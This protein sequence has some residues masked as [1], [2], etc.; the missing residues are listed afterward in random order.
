MLRKFFE[1]WV[2]GAGF[3]IAFLA[4][5]FIGLSAVFSLG[6]LQKGPVMGSVREEATPWHGPA[7]LTIHSGVMKGATSHPA[8]ELPFYELPLEEKIARSSVI[9]LARYQPAPDGRMRAV[10][11]DLLKKDEGTQFFYQVGDEYSPGSYYPQE[12]RSHGDGMVIFFSGSPAM[13]KMSMSYFGDR[14]ASL[15]DM[16]MALFRNKCSEEKPARRE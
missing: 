7:G 12:G 5:A 3:G 14:I 15:G 9:A 16:P 1:G 2:F 10:L 4:I 13:M 8:E 6:P 11:T